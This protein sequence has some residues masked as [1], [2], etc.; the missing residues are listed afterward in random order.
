M[1]TVCM[2]HFNI[3]AGNCNFQDWSSTAKLSFQCI[4]STKSVNVANANSSRNVK[5]FLLQINSANNSTFS[6]TIAKEKLTNV[7]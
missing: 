2:I 6:M 7:Y 4:V 1:L 5:T 3:D